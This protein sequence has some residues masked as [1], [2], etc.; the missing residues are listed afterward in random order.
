[1]FK[2]ER[3]RRVA[4]V[5]V[6]VMLWCSILPHASRAQQTGGGRIRQQDT[7]TSQNILTPGETDD[8]PLTARDDETLIV[9]VSSENFDPVV[10][11]ANPSGTV[12]AQN[13]DVRQGEQDALLLARVDKGGAYKVRV[14]ASK[15]VAGG[16]Y[17]LTVRRFVAANAATGARTVGALGNSLV[18]WH[19][20]DARAGQTLVVIARA[21]S[22]QPGIEIFAP[23]GEE[24]EDEDNGDGATTG[25]RASFRATRDGIHYARIT[26]GGN[27]VQPRSSYAITVAVAR[28][29]QTTIGEANQARRIDAGGL[30]L[31]T[32]DGAAGD[33]VKV[34]A[35]ADGGGMMARLSYVP[36]ADPQTGEPRAPEGSAPPFVLLP[37]D[38]K[39]SGELV[40]LVNLPGKYQV[41]VAH[42]LGVGVNYMFATARP[43]KILNVAQPETTSTLATGSSEYWSLEGDAGQIVRFEGASDQFDLALQL[44]NARGDSLAM[45][46]DGAG[47]RNALLTALLAEKGRHLLR[48]YAFGGGGGGAYRLRRMT[49]PVRPLNVGTRIAGTV[50]AGGRDIW[51]FQGHANQTVIVSARSSDFDIRLAVFGPDAAEIA[52]DDDGGEGTD[53][54]LSVRLPLDGTYT[55]W[56]TA[57]AGGG[58]YSLH[59]IEAQ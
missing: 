37:S 31:W 4:T 35:R 39:A 16:K 13:D 41:A 43:T 38:P 5:T 20:F 27:P 55:V 24:I 59:L 32:F 57:Q 51:S 49:D 10:E 47:S 53:S 42:S 19:S 22:F 25:T 2:Y 40:A 23:N 54:L 9:G 52:A 36:P 8:W 29:F 33:L 3:C 26:S 45:D 18:Q 12:V 44:F 17:T 1:M 34:Q 48:V 56:I 6:V 21:A 30:D 28:V 14:K 7:F 15:G 50:G 11:L 58:Q 46:D